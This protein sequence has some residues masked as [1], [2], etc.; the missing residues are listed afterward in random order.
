MPSK[1]KSKSTNSSGSKSTSSASGGSG[2]GQGS[3]GG[4]AVSKNFAASYGLKWYDKDDYDEAKAIQQAF[5]D[6]DAKQGK[7]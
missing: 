3:Q 4:T 5:R 1:T 7:R 2:K 6:E